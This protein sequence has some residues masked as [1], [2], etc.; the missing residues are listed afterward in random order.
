MPLLERI[1]VSLVLGIIGIAIGFLLGMA[2]ITEIA[3]FPSTY[4][5]GISFALI[6]LFWG[7]SVFEWIDIFDWFSS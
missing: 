3:G 6:G 1:F 5:L 7:T 4:I 2:G